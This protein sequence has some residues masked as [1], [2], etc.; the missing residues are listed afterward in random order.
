MKQVLAMFAVLGLLLVA[1][2][3]QVGL[4]GG[5]SLETGNARIF[6]GGTINAGV[7]GFTAGFDQ[8]RVLEMTLVNETSL[9]L[10]ITASGG[11]F[12][13]PGDG[14]IWSLLWN[15]L[16][17]WESDEL[18]SIFVTQDISSAT[19]PAGESAAFEI[20]F[21]CDLGSVYGGSY[22][23]RETRQGYRIA[24]DDG[25]GAYDFIFDVY[26]VVAC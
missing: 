4:E 3:A 23:R 13:A 15:D 1:G 24:L 20:T 5:V 6:S 11:A 2:C 19:I 8:N 16:Y 26:G 22:G 12:V 21:D 10:T 25:E 9:P 18:G 17:P 7:V 14:F